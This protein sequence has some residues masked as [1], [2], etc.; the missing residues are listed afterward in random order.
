MTQWLASPTL[1]TWSHGSSCQSCHIHLSVAYLGTDQ[2]ET[3]MLLPMA[4][5]LSLRRLARHPYLASVHLHGKMAQ[6]QYTLFI[7]ILHGSIH[8]KKWHTCTLS[9]KYLC[10]APNWFIFVLM[11]LAFA[12]HGRAIL[13]PDYLMMYN[14]VLYLG[15][16]SGTSCF[17]A[18]R[19]RSWAPRTWHAKPGIDC[20][21]GNLRI[22]YSFRA[23]YGSTGYICPWRCALIFLHDCIEFPNADV[24]HATL[25]VCGK[26]FS[27]S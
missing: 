5:A 21:Q 23:W 26:S 19:S 15:A 7:S 9:G 17:S 18:M 25:T 10:L 1:A 27:I 6:E 12:G 20:L 8:I 2:F 14:C 3:T 22:A 24:H 4:K 13:T 11:Y 16:G